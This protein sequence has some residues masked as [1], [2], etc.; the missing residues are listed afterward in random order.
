MRFK[1]TGSGSYV[2]KLTKVNDDFLDSEFFDKNGSSFENSNSEI[3]DKFVSITGIEQRKYA[4][5]K[6][7]SSDLATRAAN[8]AISD[9]NI[10]PETLDYIIFAHNFGD[11]SS[12]SK[13]IDNLP[14]LATKV[15]RNLK[16]KNPKCIGYDI[17][18]G[19]PGW[20]EGV[21]QAKSF[22]Q[23]N[24][25]SKC[26]IIGSETLSRVTDLNDRDSMI[27]ADG[28][29]AVILE[30][31]NSD[32]GGVLSHS[33]ASYTSEGENEFIF[34]GLGNK[35]DSDEGSNN[36]KYLKMHGRKVYEFALKN[37]PAAMKDCFDKAK[38]DISSLKKIFI[39]QANQKMDEAIINRFYRLYKTS[40]PDDILPMNIQEYGN[41]SVACIPT[42][43]DIVRKENYKGHKI[44][45]GDVIMFASVG[46]GMNVNAITYEV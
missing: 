30:G 17:I 5:E 44:S 13:Q 34:Y 46:A 22:I 35:L 8:N 31:E 3:I 29:G 15:K 9:S 14:A 36:N 24:M 45:K 1:I 37:V 4:S 16:I 20:V 12:N 19:C 40:P 21:I 28:A 33:S 43:F 10:D 41:S 2:P 7:N 23:S 39:H 27:Y 38:K 11:I 6:L 42:L 18:F 25:A 32:S 26:L